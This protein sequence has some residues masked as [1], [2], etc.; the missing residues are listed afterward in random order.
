LFID[1][2]KLKLDKLNLYF[3]DYKNKTTMLGYDSMD[4][5]GRAMQELLS[6]DRVTQL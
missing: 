5:E 3:S 4:A 1:K 6:S 2:S